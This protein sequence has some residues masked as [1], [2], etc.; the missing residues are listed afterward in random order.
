MDAR[1]LIEQLHQLRQTNPAEL[2]WNRYCSLMR[3]LCKA[4]HCAMVRAETGAAGLELLGRSSD[5]PTWSPTQNMPAGM[6]LLSKAASQ[7]YAQAPAQAPDGESWLV[8]VVALRGLEDAFLI[9]NIK[10]QERAQLN[11][12]T[13]RALLCV[14]FHQAATSSNT[15]NTPAELG[16]M[17]GLAA[18]VMQQQNF[19]SACL[20]LVNGIATEWQLAQVSLGWI[21]QQQIRLVAVSNLDRFERNSRRTQLTESAMMSAVAHG[22]ALWWPDSENQLVGTQAQAEFAQEFGI[23]QFLALP[24]YDVQG[25]TH[26]VLLLSFTSASYPTPNLNPLQLALELIQPRLSDLRVRS[27]DSWHRA[28]H[29]LHRWSEPV[30]GPEHTLLKLTAAAF[31]LFLLYCIFGTWSYRIDAS[32]QLNT[33]STRLISAQFDGRIDQVH[34]TAGDLVKEG[35][36]LVTLDTRELTQQKSELTAEI[37]KAETEVNKN[38][39]DGLLAETEIAQARLDQS[40]AKAQRIDNY[41]EQAVG[42]APFEGVVVEGER[43]DL[44]GAPVKKGDRIFRLAKIEGL[45]ISLMVAEKE[46]RHIVPN[47]SG[48][49]S[50]L[51]QPQYSV[52][53][54]ISSVIPV[55]QVKGQEGNLFMIRAELQEAPQAWWRPGMTGLARIDAGE[56]NILWIMTHRIVDKLRLLFWW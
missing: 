42:H 31:T 47:A 30:F 15:A 46:M 10:P 25:I 49:V 19:A 22:H 21:D 17:L 2:D 51:S 33:E 4:S 27:L 48:E 26:A 50:L 35:D 14:D 34:A 13:V 44:M 6:D 28:R 41:L 54:R 20:T 38:R 1:T 11:E 45:Y 40:L 7:G 8:L 23:E 12:L 53:I 55:A 24:I 9:L 5:Q 56:K 52:P 43:K 36:L 3:Q 37:S 29:R 39:A 32:A 16:S 18:E